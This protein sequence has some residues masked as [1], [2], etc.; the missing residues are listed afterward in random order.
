MSKRKIVYVIG[1][2]ANVENYNHELF[3]LAEK[4]LI[5]LGFVVLSPAR[6]PLGM[7]YK[8]YMEFGLTSVRLCDFIYQLPESD[9]SRG[10][11]LEKLTA[12]IMDKPVF[13]K[14]QNI[15]PMMYTGEKPFT[16]LLIEQQEMIDNYRTTIMFH[17]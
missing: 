3:N 1:P 12:Q 10:A 5:K 15:T 4:I 8:A 16:H 13:C 7:T 6:L 17:A 2:M 11:T 14:L 9:K